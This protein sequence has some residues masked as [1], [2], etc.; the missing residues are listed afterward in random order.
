MPLRQ[1]ERSDLELALQA[2]MHRMPPGKAA[3]ED[4]KD[5]RHCAVVLPAEEVRDALI[6]ALRRKD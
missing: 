2:L 6:A 3:S 4:L 5:A 1:I